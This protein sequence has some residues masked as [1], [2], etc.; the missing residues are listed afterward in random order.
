[1]IDKYSTNE[2]GQFRKECEAVYLI[3]LATLIFRSAGVLIH[4]ALGQHEIMF[5]IIIK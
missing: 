1:M 3:A 5:L 2:I 4:A